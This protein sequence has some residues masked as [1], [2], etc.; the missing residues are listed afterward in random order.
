MLRKLFFG[1]VGL[2]FWTEGTVQAEG[3]LPVVSPN[4]S[5]VVI[6]S[7]KTAKNSKWN[8]V[9]KELRKKYDGSLIIYKKGKVESVLPALKTLHPRYAA[10]V[11]RPEE[12]D[13]SFIVTIHRMTRQ[14]DDD[15]YTD[16]RWGV[17]TGYKAE[18]ALRIAKRKK[19]LLISS[20]ASS[21][22]PSC[23]K[24]LDHGFASNESDENAF[25]IKKKGGDIEE[26]QV[27]PDPVEQLVASFN[28]KTQAPDCFTTS[29]HA[30]EQGWQVIFNK[31]RGVFRCEKGKLYGLNSEKMRFDIHSPNP[32]IY[33]PLGNCSIGHIFEK[34]CMMT[35]WIHSGGVHQMMGYTVVS[36]CGYMGWGIGDFMN[37]QYSLSEAF[38]FNNQ[39]LIWE[40]EKLIPQQSSIEFKSFEYADRLEFAE[41]HQ[42]TDHKV[43]GYL[44][45]RD[46]VA[47][48]G[49]PAWEA[50]YPIKDPAWTVSGK[51]QG[52]MIEF[53]V[54]V[55]ADGPWGKRP[56][57][58]PLPA[59]FSQISK[60]SCSHGLT[61]LVTD[62]FILLPVM[63][64]E[65]KAGDEIIV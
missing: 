1:L 3:V 19:P 54:E 29:G 16:L 5:Y 64:T 12:A 4:Q 33:L 52:D 38:Y 22:G 6:V 56:L 50:R 44:W 7:D 59:R 18:D 49:D 42:I 20:A 25:F 35:A 63:G 13:R 24:E 36:F 32:K 62:D 23:F 60:V 41:E 61:P 39:A 57:A 34:D 55:L 8:S 37:N 9:V 14:L 31:D 11:A 21:M 30:W 47:L 45:D 46:V 26:V 2:L 51:Q 27:S 43:L 15:P 58:I 48:Y 53:N 17:V 40:L 65:R 10:F 28:D